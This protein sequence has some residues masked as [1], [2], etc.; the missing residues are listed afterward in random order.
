MTLT[1]KLGKRIQ[2]THF[3]DLW[4]NLKKKKVWRFFFLNFSFMCMVQFLGTLKRWQMAQF[5][6]IINFLFALCKRNFLYFFRL[7]KKRICDFLK[8]NL[9]LNFVEIL[10]EFC[11]NKNKINFSTPKISYLFKL[12]S[13][14]IK[15]FA[16][17]KIQLR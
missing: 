12:P 17:H 14:E 8:K 5:F 7:K 13:P 2:L 1:R 6:F 10:S 16:H 3:N 9:V 4:F 11:T 15:F